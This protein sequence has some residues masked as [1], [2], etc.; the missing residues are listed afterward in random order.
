MSIAVVLAGV[1]LGEGL[2]SGG[3]F[4]GELRA[5]AALG[6]P[7]VGESDR[8]DRGDEDFGEA[9]SEA[10]GHRRLAAG[11]KPLSFLAV[12]LRRPERPAPSA[13]R[14]AEKCKG[15]RHFERSETSAPLRAF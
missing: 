12:F 2:A 9:K 14:F 7:G 15:G 13:K 3:E 11:L 10:R 4:G 5:I 6:I 1:G 8:E